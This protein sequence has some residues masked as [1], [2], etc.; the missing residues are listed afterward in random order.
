MSYFLVKTAPVS[1][2]LTVPTE[3]PTRRWCLTSI[4]RGRSK[5]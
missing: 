4:F 2:N 1:L 5:L 3:H